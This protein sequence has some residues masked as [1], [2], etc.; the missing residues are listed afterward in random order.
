[1][2]HRQGDSEESLGGFYST[3]WGYFHEQKWGIMGM[4][5]HCFF[6]QEPIGTN[7]TLYCTRD[8]E[9]SLLQW[10][11][12]TIGIPSDNHG[13]GQYPIYRFDFLIEQFPFLAD[14]NCHVSSPEGTQK[15]SQKNATARN[16]WHLCLSVALRC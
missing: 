11:S 8:I 9:I 10:V 2:T 13:N 6:N 12:F 5:S 14:F 3:H 4:Q 1:M 16:D 15:R 7:M